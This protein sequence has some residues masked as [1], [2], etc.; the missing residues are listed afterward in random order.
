[1]YYYSIYL[2]GLGGLL[3]CQFKIFVKDLGRAD[4]G[5]Q[6]TKFPSFIFYSSKN[7]EIIGTK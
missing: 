3:H 7:I 5:L 1:M 2:V 4:N 6:V